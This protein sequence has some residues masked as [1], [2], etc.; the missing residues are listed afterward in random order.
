MYWTLLLFFRICY[1]GFNELWGCS[2][3]S[4]TTGTESAIA[5]QR[6]RSAPASADR[7]PGPPAGP[8][9]PGLA[10]CLPHRTECG[11]RNWSNGRNNTTAVW[12][13]MSSSPGWGRRVGARR[14]HRR[15]RPETER[16]PYPG[17]AEPLSL[18]GRSGKR[19]KI[20]GV[21]LKRHKWVSY[22]NSMFTFRSDSVLRWSLSFQ[23]VPNLPWSL[24]G[25]KYFIVAAHGR[26]ALVEK[27]WL[28][29]GNFL[30]EKKNPLS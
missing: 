13:F 14:R 30:R 24:L 3:D 23:K 2:P 8:G 17:A 9:G 7:P 21:K 11:D 27:N 19:I 10:P 29:C 22:T 26:C 4:A 20:K 1:S 5:I 16:A 12:W 15:R 18:E 25:I 28:P 6:W